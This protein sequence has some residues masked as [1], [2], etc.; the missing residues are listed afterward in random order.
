MSILQKRLLSALVMLIIVI[1]ILIIGGLPFLALCGILSVLALKEL[2]D[3][4]DKAK[5]IPDILKLL[6]FILIICLTFSEL[7]SSSLSLGLS[8]QWLGITALVFLIPCL[9]IKDYDTKDAFYLLGITLFLGLFFN[10]VVLIRLG[11]LS[12]LIYLALITI[13][14]DTFA[15]IIGSL[16]GKTKFTPI[17]PN[18][19]IEG[20][21][22]G[23]IVGSIISLIYYMNIIRVWSLP[24]ALIITILLSLVSEIGDLF[25]SKIKRENK[26]K[27]FSHLI[28]GH[29]GILDRLDSLIFVVITFVILINIF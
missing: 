2:I 5:K 27:D 15:Y 19:T 18:K 22:G 17:S 25:F 12:I 7:E 3:L 6:S 23:I 29:G 14:T 26:V 21:L 11:S 28:P 1:P 9:F 4:K 20:C 24:K 13:L 8:Y 16:I 10:S